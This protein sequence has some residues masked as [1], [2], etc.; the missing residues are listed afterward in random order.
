MSTEGE[1]GRGGFVVEG[2]LF[3]TAATSSS[4]MRLQRRK[5]RTYENKREGK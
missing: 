4:R 2:A 3:A 1:W 5:K